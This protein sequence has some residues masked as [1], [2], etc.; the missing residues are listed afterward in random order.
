YFSSEVNVELIPAWQV[1][2]SR[3][4]D[5]NRDRCGLVWQQRER[6]GPV[7]RERTA[8]AVDGAARSGVTQERHTCLNLPG[9]QVRAGQLELVPVGD[10]DWADIL[11]QT[12]RLV[13]VEEEVGIR[14]V[15][16]HRSRPLHGPAGEQR[17]V[18]QPRLGAR[19]ERLIIPVVDTG[20]AHDV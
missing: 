20:V 1:A 19:L 9:Q 17:N 6:D 3:R 2:G 15:A 5:W 12:A 18:R 16:C 7:D 4:D 8:H 10:A 14:R 13:A 11:V